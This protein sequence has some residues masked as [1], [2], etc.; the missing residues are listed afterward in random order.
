MMPGDQH[1]DPPGED[2]WGWAMKN[3]GIPAAEALTPHE[4]DRLLLDA[5]VD[6][7]KELSGPDG[8]DECCAQLEDDEHY[9][10]LT[11]AV[12]A[13]PRRV[14]GE[15]DHSGEPLLYADVPDFKRQ[16]AATVRRLYEA[17]REWEEEPNPITDADRWEYVRDVLA[18]MHSPHM[19]GEHAYR[20]RPFL[21]RGPTFTAAID[22][23]IEEL[24]LQQDEA[25]EDPRCAI[26]TPD[27][28]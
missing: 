12:H 23:A 27:Y 15:Y 3:T 25:D 16:V 19:G 22:R 1:I 18:Q 5:L 13:T 9:L 2:Y 28:P 24:R 11:L 26:E 6:V 21:G 14:P 7:A 4:Y 20:F 17:T 10:C 8:V